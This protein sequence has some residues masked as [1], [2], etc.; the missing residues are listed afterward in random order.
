MV[1]RIVADLT[2]STGQCPRHLDDAEPSDNGGHQ[3]DRGSS[4][5]DGGYM[6]DRRHDDIMLEHMRAS[7]WLQ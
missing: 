5:R 4:E 1:R 7:H 3:A 6:L 2:R